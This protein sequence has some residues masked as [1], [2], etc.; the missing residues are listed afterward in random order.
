M[1]NRKTVKPTRVSTVR[2]TIVLETPKAKV[3]PFPPAKCMAGDWLD[4]ATRSVQPYEVL[5]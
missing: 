1:A 4:R 2:E 3:Y 5:S